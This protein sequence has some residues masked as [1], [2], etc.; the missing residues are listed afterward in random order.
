MDKHDGRKTRAREVSAAE[1]RSLAK[2]LHKQADEIESLVDAISRVNG[3]SVRVDGAA[4]AESA[5]STLRAY[6][7]NV[8]HGLARLPVE[9]GV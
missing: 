6:A 9:S 8:R 5:I 4:M 2:Q 1:A 7:A 3:K